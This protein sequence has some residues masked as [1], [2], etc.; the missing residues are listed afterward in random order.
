MSSGSFSDEAVMLFVQSQSLKAMAFN[1]LT[2]DLAILTTDLSTTMYSL[3]QEVSV[4]KSVTR[5]VVEV[6]SVARHRHSN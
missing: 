6:S 2:T 4:R 5:L 1:A 3:G